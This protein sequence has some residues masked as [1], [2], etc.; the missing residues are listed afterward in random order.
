MLKLLLADW[1]HADVAAIPIREQ[2]FIKEL[3]RPESEE[4]SQADEPALHVVASLD[5]N[6]IGTARLSPEGVIGHMA[7]LTEFRRQG[8]GS[9]MLQKLIE[10]AKQSRLTILSLDCPQQL[11]SL[12]QQQGFLAQGDAF[13][14]EGHPYIKM[15]L[16]ISE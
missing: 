13:Q 4:W 16:T 7:V 1:L 10:A 9:A 12:F 2:V 6:A 11:M 3:Q 15:V 8:V 14:H 5:G